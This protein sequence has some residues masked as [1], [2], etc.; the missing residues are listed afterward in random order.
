MLAVGKRVVEKGAKAN[1]TGWFDGNV[2]EVRGKS[3]RTSGLRAIP[4]VSVG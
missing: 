1:T 4:G 3:P 2:W